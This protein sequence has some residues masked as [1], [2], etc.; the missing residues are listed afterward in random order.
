M[1]SCSSYS[2]SNYLNLIYSPKKYLDHN[3]SSTIATNDFDTVCVATG[4]LMD[5]IEVT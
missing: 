3:G 2:K 1:F 4:H 5:G